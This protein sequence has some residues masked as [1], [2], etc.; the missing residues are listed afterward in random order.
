MRKVDEMFWEI[1]KTDF[2]WLMKEN[3]SEDKDSLMG[4]ENDWNF[5][6]EQKNNSAKIKICKSFYDLFVSPFSKIQLFRYRSNVKFEI[7]ESWEKNTYRYYDVEHLNEPNYLGGASYLNI[8]ELSN[9]LDFMSFYNFILKNNTP[10]SYITT[11]RGNAFFIPQ[12]FSESVDD[13][14]MSAFNFEFHESG[15]YSGLKLIKYILIQFET[16]SYGLLPLKNTVEENFQP[17]KH[18][19]SFAIN[20]F[21]NY[22]H[23]GDIYF[24]SSDGLN[25]A[26]KNVVQIINSYLLE[27][28][29]SSKPKDFY[30]DTNFD[31]L[32][33]SHQ[34][35]VYEIRTE[36]TFFKETEFIYTVN[37][38]ETLSAGR[39]R[40]KWAGVTARINFYND[41]I[42]E[43]NGS[44]SLESLN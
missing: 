6:K 7:G 24:F 36:I 23:E 27:N 5:F 34:F 17:N 30:F 39:L 41:E 37:I 15:A 9:D 29:K 20:Y 14:K 43:F 32:E 35:N 44:K 19:F 11:S 28:T 26:K 25:Y 10:K 16:R 2:Y 21:K 40:E 33:Y 22:Y 1:I 18:F 4:S 13:L 8:K 12:D 38:G 31:I 42:L 3:E